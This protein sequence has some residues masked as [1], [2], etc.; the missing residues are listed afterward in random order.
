MADEEPTASEWSR[1]GW[2]EWKGRIGVKLENV[3]NGQK[4]LFNL[5]D[6]SRRESSAIREEIGKIKGT[7]TAYGAVA[8]III[9]L[10]LAV[11]MYAVRPQEKVSAQPR[12]DTTERIADVE[13]RPDR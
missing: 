10:I 2:A 1:L 12:V 5:F 9:T 8:S 3:E 7:A 13:Q 4:T 11:I 6:A